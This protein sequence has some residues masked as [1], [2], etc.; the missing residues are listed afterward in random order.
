MFLDIVVGGFDIVVL[1]GSATYGLSPDVTDVQVI[2]SRLLKKSILN[3][4]DPDLY[5]S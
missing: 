2:P 4:L 3:A 1:L 5:F